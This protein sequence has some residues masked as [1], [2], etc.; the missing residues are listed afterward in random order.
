MRSV[1]DRLV[2][3]VRKIDTVAR[4]G[5]D[6][7]VVLLSDLR[8]PHIAEKIAEMIVQNLAAPVLY[9][10]RELPVSVSIGVCA[11]SAGELDAETLMKNADAAL[12][13]AKA[14]GRNCYEVFAPAMPGARTA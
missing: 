10:E 3:A 9:E 6:E 4:I 2:E 12:Y 13:Q 7:F 5:G 8:D 14:N 1:A 11:A